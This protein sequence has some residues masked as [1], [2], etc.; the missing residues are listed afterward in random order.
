LVNL[1]LPDAPRRNR[2]V[3]PAADDMVALQ[4]GE[5]FLQLLAQRFIFMGI[6]IKKTHRLWEASRGQ[7]LWRR[8]EC[9][10][11]CLGAAARL[12]CLLQLVQLCIHLLAFGLSFGNEGVQTQALFSPGFQVTLLLHGLQDLAELIPMSLKFIYS[13]G[14][15]C[16]MTHHRA[17]PVAE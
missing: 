9:G 15:S 3:M 17:L 10:R 7:W 11:G 1:L 6:G 13:S 2:P 8:R 12:E 14:Q 5:M 4:D 16:L